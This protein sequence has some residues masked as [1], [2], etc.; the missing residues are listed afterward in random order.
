MTV[1]RSL[2]AGL[3][4]IITAPTFGLYTHSKWKGVGETL[5][6]K[7]VSEMRNRLF[8]NV[9]GGLMNSDD[10][11]VDAYELYYSDERLMPAY[12]FDLYE[13]NHS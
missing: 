2:C 13:E 3:G 10:C 9:N 1:I 8:K 6:P 12:L 11:P 5:R 4:P 7:N